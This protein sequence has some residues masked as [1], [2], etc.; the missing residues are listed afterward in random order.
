MKMARAD[1]Q[2]PPQ[3]NPKMEFQSLDFSS[4][5]IILLISIPWNTRIMSVAIVHKYLPWINAMLFTEMIKNDNNS[6]AK[7]RTKRPSFLL[8]NF[9]K[10]RSI[11]GLNISIHFCF[12]TQGRPSANCRSACITQTL[13]VYQT[14]HCSSISSALPTHTYCILVVSAQNHPLYAKPLSNYFQHSFPPVYAQPVCTTLTKSSP[15]GMFI[16][17]VREPQDFYISKYFTC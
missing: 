13:R 1:P 16:F 4:S 11:D 14:A 6:D 15:H 8:G 9:Q 7:N 10:E 5:I 17:D 3:V 2:A 12:F